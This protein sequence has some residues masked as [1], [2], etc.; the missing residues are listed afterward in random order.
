MEL[1]RR[2]SAKMQEYRS[3]LG[4]NCASNISLSRF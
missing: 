4:P 1:R 2:E 3:G